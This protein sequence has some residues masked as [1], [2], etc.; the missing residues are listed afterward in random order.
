MPNY[1]DLAFSRAKQKRAAVRSVLVFALIMIVPVVALTMLL[2]VPDLSV[3]LLILFAVLD[4]LCL[5][6][7]IMAPVVLR[8][9]F[10]EIEGGELD[11]A[12]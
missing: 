5:L 4:V 1:T 9:R 12:R 11:E 3:L 8:Q 2:F 7:L 6:P 10:R